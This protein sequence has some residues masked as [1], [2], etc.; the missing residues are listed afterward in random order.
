MVVL[1]ILIEFA[2]YSQT[3]GITTGLGSSME[4]F[5]F[6][7]AIQMLVFIT[8]SVSL[9]LATTIASADVVIPDDTQ[10]YLTTTET[11]IGKK[12]E[13][14][15][16]RIVRA[17]VWRDVMVDGYV[18]IKGGTS[19]TATVSSLKS[20]GIFGVKGK[21]SLAAVETKTVDGQT[22]YLTG[23]YNK[24]GGGRMALALGVG[25]LLFWPALFI[26]GKA[27]ELPTGTVMD[28]FTVGSQTVVMG[29]SKQPVRS[30]NLGSLVSGFEVEVLYDKLLEEKKPKYF[31]FLITTDSNAPAEFTIDVING[32]KIE[33]IPLAVL[34]SEFIAGED[35]KASRANVK[36]KTLAK[37]F[38]KGIN[39]F[40]I[41]YFDGE[42]RVAE[43]VIFQI[44]M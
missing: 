16:G 14:A 6:G 15:V 23:G 31:D 21:M 2:G 9:V 22:V 32:S 17:R 40:E 38:K 25:L 29:G 12:N 37:K 20:R 11:V 19:A 30:I 24:E 26:P 36:I 28:S 13:T 1:S 34:S 7:Q 10:V 42:E 35:E 5:R 4:T 41:S 33:P 8:V 39:T 3:A 44:E 18:V 27:A 43:E